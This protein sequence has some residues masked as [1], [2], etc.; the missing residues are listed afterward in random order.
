MSNDEK[1]EK[2]VGRQDE[3]VPEEKG[4]NQEKQ[5]GRDQE[6]EE[7]Q[8]EEA[9]AGDLEQGTGSTRERRIALLEVAEEAYEDRSKQA[10][11]LCRQLAFAGIALIWVFRIERGASKTLDP[12]LVW[13]AIFIVCTLA[14]DFL[15][16]VS[17]TLLWGAHRRVW[18]K[19]F[20]RDEPIPTEAPRWINWPAIAFFWLKIGAIAVA[21]YGILSY[22]IRAVV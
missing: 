3:E 9:G 4:S 7:G 18:E 22:L 1:S 17:A 19:R 6:A 21:Y 10:S 15:H 11:D 12:G 5:E 20:L 13:P 2:E 14:L 16:Y 8:E